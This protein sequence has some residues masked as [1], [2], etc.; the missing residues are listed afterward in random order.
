MASEREALESPVEQG[1]TERRPYVFKFANYGL[2]SLNSATVAV[3]D[4]TDD[5]FSDVTNTLMPTN[6]PSISNTDVTTSLLRDGTAEHSYRVQC[7]VTSNTTIETLFIVV[8]F[9]R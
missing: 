3:Y 9:K 2:S 6:S 5:G 4:V 7:D 1:T 8:N